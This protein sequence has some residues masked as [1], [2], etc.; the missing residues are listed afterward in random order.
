MFWN[1]SNFSARFAVDDSN[2]RLGSCRIWWYGW[3][4]KNW[5]RK[6]IL[7]QISSH[8]W[9]SPKIWRVSCYT[10]QYLTHLKHF[11]LIYADKAHFKAI[12]KEIW[13]RLNH[14]VIVLY[15][16]NSDVKLKYVFCPFSIFSLFLYWFFY[17][18]FLI[19][20]SILSL[21]LFAF[22]FWSFFYYY[23]IRGNF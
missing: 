12:L 20:T 19:S 17:L 9:S 1:R 10:A 18:F 16:I 14:T 21:F 7:Q 15:I 11:T 22:I 13:A 5:F 4:N 3:R 23:L 8:L 6:Q 2:L